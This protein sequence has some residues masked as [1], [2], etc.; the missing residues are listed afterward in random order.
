MPPVNTIGGIGFAVM[1]VWLSACTGI[2]Q[3]WVILRGGN[4]CLA[5]GDGRGR[6]FDK[7]M[8]IAGVN[9]NVRAVV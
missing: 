3:A 6:L 9:K 4:R 7:A 8:W 5:G 2:G 1:T